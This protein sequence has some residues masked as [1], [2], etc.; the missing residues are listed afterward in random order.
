M[1]YELTLFWR[2]LLVAVA[3]WV[4][5]HQLD[6]IEYLQE[7][8]R[9][10]RQHL[11][12]QRIRFTDQQRRRLAAKAKKIGRKVLGELETI[13]TP[14]TLLRWHRRLIAR[15]YDSS[16]QRRPGR[17][18]VMATIRSFVVLFAI[19]NRSWGYTR[20]QGAL[21]NLGHQVGRGTISNILAQN[22]IEP[23]PKRGKTLSWDQFCPIRNRRYG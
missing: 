12:G 3:G 5:R 6:I 22:G 17:P 1:A 20:I 16:L 21:K 9:V 10:L 8:N 15:K 11:K 23:A 18:P 4:N 2:Y 14:D 13:V 19:E 7:E